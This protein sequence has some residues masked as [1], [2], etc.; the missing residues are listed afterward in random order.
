MVKLGN[1]SC[2]QDFWRYFN[3]LDDHLS[4]DAPLLPE[5]FTLR[6]FK[7][8]IRPVWEHPYNI[9]GGQWVG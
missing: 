8:H 5:K 6:L 7:S 3:A 1:F 4:E 9:D 2:V